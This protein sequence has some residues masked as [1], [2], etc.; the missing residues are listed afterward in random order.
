YTLKSFTYGT[1]DLLKDSLRVAISDK[2]QLN[3]GFDTS[4]VTP[5]NVSGRVTGLLTTKGVR[6]VLWSPNLGST[7]APVNPDGS[8]TFSK[9]LSGSYNA[10]LSLSGLSAGTAVTVG[11]SDVTGV[12]IAYPRDFIVTGH[13]IVE[14]SAAAPP[15]IVV[16][17]RSGTG[18]AIPS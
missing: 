9:V 6:V 2:A 12:V 7:E 14:G 3:I 1:T 4:A 18:R 17:A 11:T 16:E 5:A 15:P 8:F 13:I 10:R